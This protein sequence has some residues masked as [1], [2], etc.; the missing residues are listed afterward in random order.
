MN[1]NFSLWLLFGSTVLEVSNSKHDLGLT[2]RQRRQSEP[3]SLL[4][5]HQEAVKLGQ[6]AGSG[7][8]KSM[9][10]QAEPGFWS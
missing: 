9:K 2:E 3:R 1:K 6:E 4:D 10:I 8:F 5:N 7:S